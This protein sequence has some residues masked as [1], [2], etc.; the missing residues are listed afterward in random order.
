M[1]T[2]SGHYVSVAVTKPRKERQALSQALFLPTY[3]LPMGQTKLIKIKYL[4]RIPPNSDEPRSM[5]GCSY[6]V[7]ELVTYLID[8]TKFTSG[9]A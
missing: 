1:E 3:L 7:C 6:L 5:Q 4:P 2:E 8:A 9:T